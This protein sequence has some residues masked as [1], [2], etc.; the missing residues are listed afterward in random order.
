LSGGAVTGE[1]PRE[2]IQT[3]CGAPA[4][5]IV[6]ARLGDDGYLELLDRAHASGLVTDLERRQQRL[7]HLH[8]RRVRHERPPQPGDPG[9][10][11]H[12]LAL[13]EQGQLTVDDWHRLSSEH[14]RIV[15]AREARS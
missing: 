12:L 8:V 10:L 7:V 13:G 1:R 6:A 15:R 2:C 4:S 3:N 11:E 9:Y 14:E 5:G